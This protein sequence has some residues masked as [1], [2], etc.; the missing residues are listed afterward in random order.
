MTY[1]GATQSPGLGQESAPDPFRAWPRR[2]TELGSSSV[3]P[4]KPLDMLKLGCA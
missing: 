4:D 2:P 1:P 3:R